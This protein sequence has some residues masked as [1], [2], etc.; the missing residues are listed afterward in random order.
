MSSSAAPRVRVRRCT[1]RV[2]R[3][4]GWGWGDPEQY[5]SRILAALEDALAAVAADVAMQDGAECH[6][7]EPVT[8]HVTRDGRVTIETRRA[9]VGQIEAAAAEQSPPLT[10]TT[11]GEERSA[12]EA[13]SATELRAEIASQDWDAVA[14]TLDRWSRSGRLRAITRSLPEGVVRAW[15]DALVQASRD[16]PWATAAVPAEAVDA[17]A[18]SLLPAAG[19]DT[20]EA[21]QTVDV[22]LVAAAVVAAT[23]GR[24]PDA[25]TMEHVVWRVTRD[26]PRTVTQDAVESRGEVPAPTHLTEPARLHRPRAA[27]TIAAGPAVV[28]A[29][30]FLT[31]IQ[32]A[33]LGFTD[34]AAAALAAAR[35]EAPARVFAAAVAGKALDPPKRGWERTEVELAAVRLA[36]GLE[37]IDIDAGLGDLVAA[38]DIVVPAWRAAL[39]DLY[40]EGRASDADVCVTVSGDAR[41]CGEAIGLLPIAWVEGDAELGRVLGQLGDPAVKHSDVLLQLVELFAPRRGIAGLDAPVLERHLASIVGTAIGSL[42]QELWGSEADVPL[43]FERLRDLEARVVVGDRVTIGLPRGQRW[44][45]LRRAGL[46]DA[47]PVGW[48]P[49]GIWELVTW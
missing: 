3:Q 28:P 27:A 26:R 23:G 5:V 48:A 34:P 40:V 36:S 39:V 10:P 30:P 24:L 35:V 8:L 43:A 42:G 37:Q 18:T 22:L 19:A 41:I 46:L 45:D 15:V 31:L 25:P 33:R 17:I 4:G 2:R 38:S 14:V 16:A 44:L 47:W 1:V 11:V 20:T 13:E 12:D 32:L 29:L 21:D 49:G 7:I 6:L 9:L